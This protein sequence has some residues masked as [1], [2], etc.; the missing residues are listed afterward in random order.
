MKKISIVLI[1]L[2]AIGLVSAG[3]VEY[4]GQ[5]EATIEI[6]PAVDL[7]GGEACTITDAIGGNTYE[8]DEIGINNNADVEVD[9]EITTE[10]V[11]E[12]DVTD[13][14]YIGYLNLA[15]KVV[16]FGSEPW[17]L[18]LDGDTAT[19]KYTVVGDEFSAE[20]VSG[21]LEGYELIYYK[22]N[23]DR[24]NDPASA[25]TISQVIV[26][27]KNLPYDNDG[28]VDEYDYCATGEYDTCHGAKLWYVLSDAI[29]DG[30]ID[31]A[32]ADEFLFETELIQYNA[33]GVI[34]MY[35]NSGLGITPTFTTHVLADGT[36]VITTT[37]DL[38]ED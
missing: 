8:C 35:P 9:V 14:R 5:R 15:Q 3:L 38:N 10:I 13:I 31:W 37:V 16:E 26:S 33:D 2:V 21:A 1:A 6:T 24:F 32:R 20:I 25:R 11:E 29:T 36:I 7:T 28:N 17:D 22:D 12:E 27:G 4:F 19:V 34:T 18:L 23:S 30:N